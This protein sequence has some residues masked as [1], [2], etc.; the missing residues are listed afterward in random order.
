MYR[1]G[2]GGAGRAARARL[3]EPEENWNAAHLSALTTL[4]ACETRCDVEVIMQNIRRILLNFR[5]D[6]E[7]PTA[8][9]YAVMMA[10]VVAVCLSAISAVGSKAKTTFTNVANSIGGS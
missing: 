5:Q 1:R 3:P 2:A 9:E 4:G 7:G 8:V 10:L 6:E